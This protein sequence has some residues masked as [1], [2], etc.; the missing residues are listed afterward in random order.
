MMFSSDVIYTKVVVNYLVKLLLKFGSLWLS[1][2]GV[3]PI[4]SKGSEIVIFLE[5]WTRYEKPVC[6]PT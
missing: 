4:L 5:F 1:S 3:A 2:L 6:C